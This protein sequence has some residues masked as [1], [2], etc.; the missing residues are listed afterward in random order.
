MESIIKDEQLDQVSGGEGR[1]PYG[2]VSAIES[3]PYAGPI[4]NYIAE[5][6]K[7]G[8]PKRK[9]WGAHLAACRLQAASFYELCLQSEK[10]VIDWRVF[11]RAGGRPAMRRP[12]AGKSWKKAGRPIKKTI[13]CSHYFT[14]MYLSRR[15]VK[16]YSNL[17]D[18]QY[19][20]LDAGASYVNRQRRA[21]RRG[22]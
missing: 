16:W 3:S 5:A 21:V 18:N 8:Y 7:N 2:S 13:K 12:S 17:N 15:Y 14:E 6:K 4:K 1:K 10:P 22:S 11:C 20:M 19:D 9:E